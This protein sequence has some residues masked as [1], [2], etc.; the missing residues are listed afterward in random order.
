MRIKDTYKIMNVV[1]NYVLIN[2]SNVNSSII[3]LNETSKEI[4]ELLIKGESKDSIIKYILGN[5][6]TDIDTINKDYDSLIESLKK[7]NVLDD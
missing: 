7:A 4:V 6:N 2:T 5:Y 1:N 3:K